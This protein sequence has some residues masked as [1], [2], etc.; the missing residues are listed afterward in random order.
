M[1]CPHCQSPNNNDVDDCTQC[2]ESLYSLTP[3]SVVGG[4]Y[5]VLSRLGKG[6]MGIVYKVR[7][8]ELDEIL[9]LKVLRSDIA[10]SPDAKRRFLAEIK[11]ARK[12]SHKNVCRVH[13]YGREEDLLYIVMELVEGV[14][15]KQVLR[16]SGPLPPAEALDVAVH[17]AEALQAIHDEGIIHRDLKTPNVMRDANGIVKLMDFGIAKSQEP[18]LTGATATGHIV[19]TPEYMSPEQVRGEKI[20]GRSDIYALGIVIFELFTG[21]TPFR[22]DNTI[23]TLFKQIQDPPPLYGPEAARIPPAVIPI[24]AKALAKDREER[25]GS[26]WEV[27]EALRAVAGGRGTRERSGPMRVVTSTSPPRLQPSSETTPIPT[28]VP[29][30]V[31]TAA[32]PPETVG[33]QPLT[34]IERALPRTSTRAP[35]V[36]AATPRSFAPWVAAIAVGVLLVSAVTTWLI[37]PK[38]TPPPSSPSNVVAPRILQ[39][40]TAA[41]LELRS[42]TPGTVDVAAVST[43]AVLPRSRTLAPLVATQAPT[44]T[45]MPALRPTTAPVA[46]PTAPIRPVIQATLPPVTPSPL[47]LPTVTVPAAATGPSWQSEAAVRQAIKD[48]EAAFA[49]LDTRAI[50]KV[51]PKI[52]KVQLDGFKN[53]R[54]YDIEIAVRSI[55]ITGKRARVACQTKAML[56]SFTN[57]EHALPVIDEIMTFEYRNDTWVRVE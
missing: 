54:G 15:L 57:K 10:G 12:V 21:N 43:P 37:W 20:D 4:R 19:G 7:D 44:R 50:A 55:E 28:A 11:L 3:G 16:E 18:S 40:G 24:I 14:D 45:T 47:A 1:L 32:G 5:E 9:A 41:P 31:R 53:F 29:T 25:Y 46:A 49:S 42:P 52:D 6:G 30:E 27:A 33:Q 2:G 35:R 38:P 36:A 48:Y 17:L 13:D 8:R 26:A 23:T 51:Y 22:G 39:T 56:K 34:E